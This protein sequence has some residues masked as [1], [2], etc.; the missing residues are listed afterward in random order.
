[1]CRSLPIFVF[2][3]CLIISGCSKKQEVVWKSG[4]DRLPQDWDP[5]DLAQANQAALAFEEGKVPAE[6]HILIWQALEDKST[7]RR[8]DHAII[9][10]RLEDGGHGRWMLAYVYRSPPQ[11]QAVGEWGLAVTFDAEPSPQEHRREFD[12]AP[13]NDDI[14]EFLR[15]SRW[16]F[17]ADS[18]MRMLDSAICA[19]TWKAVTGEEPPKFYERT[20]PP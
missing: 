2:V 18:Y 15:D 19:G 5:S 14:R 10:I 4:E 8:V 7:H 1:M 3:C 13:N 17:G 20:W 12:H 16:I 9:W 11:P 6:S